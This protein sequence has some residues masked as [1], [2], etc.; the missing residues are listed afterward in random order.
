MEEY[1]IALKMFSKTEEWHGEMLT[2]EYILKS[3]T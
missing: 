2:T 1:A 3:E